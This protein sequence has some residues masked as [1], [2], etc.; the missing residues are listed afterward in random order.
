MR[1]NSVTLLRRRPDRRRGRRRAV[2]ACARSRGC[3]RR[4]L[5]GDQAAREYSLIKP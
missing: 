3:G 1:R 4:P 2:C 5:D